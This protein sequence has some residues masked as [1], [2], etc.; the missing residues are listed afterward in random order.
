M[1][2]KYE[3]LLL[4]KNRKNL[5]NYKFIAKFLIKNIFRKRKSNKKVKQLLFIF[6]F[7]KV[8]FYFIIIFTI[9]RARGQGVAEKRAQEATQ[10]I[11]TK[12]KKYFLVLVVLRGRPCQNFFLFFGG[13]ALCRQFGKY[14]Q[15]NTRTGRSADFIKSDF[16]SE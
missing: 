9:R 8:F 15:E 7:S 10:Q 3:N 5:Q 4:G 2:K 14:I 12:I 16:I 1:R 13:V 6:Y 11:F